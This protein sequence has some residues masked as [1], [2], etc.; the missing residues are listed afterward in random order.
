MRSL[1]VCETEK[2]RP[3]RAVVASGRN[4]EGFLHLRLSMF[5]SIASAHKDMAGGL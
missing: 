1:E 4:T 3:V 5:S 2:R